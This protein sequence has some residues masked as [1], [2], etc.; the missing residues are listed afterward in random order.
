[1]AGNVLIG[2][3]LSV[4][5]SRTH[6]IAEVAGEEVTASEYTYFD[7]GI[8]AQ[9]GF[10]LVDSL[11][12]GVSVYFSYY[13]E[14]ETESEDAYTRLITA[15]GPQIGY[16]FNT[17]SNLVPYIGA[18]VLYYGV[19]NKS[20]PAAGAE[21]ETKWSGYLIEPRGGINFFISPAVAFA[22][23]LFFQYQTDKLKDSDPE[24]AEKWTTFGLRLGF[25]VFL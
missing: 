14:K 20:K 21:T 16:F 23:T 25:N 12:V 2:G 1:M 19:T 10:F 9:A 22:A 3:D 13:S 17:Y 8:D 6:Y 18:A 24:V 7:I 5:P 4:S 15:L 11:E